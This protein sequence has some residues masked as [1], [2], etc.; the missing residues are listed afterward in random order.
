MAAD[1]LALFE[2]R[3]YGDS[4]NDVPLF[5]HVTHPVVVNADAVLAAH[6]R[7]MGWPELRLA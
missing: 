1:V 2:G 3:F 5:T 6:A 4:L 7:P